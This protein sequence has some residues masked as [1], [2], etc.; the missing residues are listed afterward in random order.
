MLAILL[1]EMRFLWKD[2]VEDGFFDEP[3]CY[4]VARLFCP[5]GRRIIKGFRTEDLLVVDV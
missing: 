3:Q 4:E 2:K 5:V 1:L